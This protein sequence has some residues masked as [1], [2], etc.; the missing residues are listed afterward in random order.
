MSQTYVQIGRVIDLAGGAYPGAVGRDGP[1]PRLDAPGKRDRQLRRDLRTLSRFIEVYCKHNH[2]GVLKRDAHLKH[3]DVAGVSGH[4]VRLCPSC[5][6]LLTHAFTKRSACPMNPK[7]ACKHCPNHCYHPEYREK[8]REV[9]R[10]SGMKI[11]LTGRLDYLLHL[12]W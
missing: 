3:H 7:P 5:T 11:L 6:K 1:L 12:L 9:M 10:F 8:I 4:D 2:P